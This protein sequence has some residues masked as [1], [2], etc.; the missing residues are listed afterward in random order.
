MKE[1][2]RKWLKGRRK[3]SEEQTRTTKTVNVEEQGGTKMEKKANKN[4]NVE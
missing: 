4:N 3:Y 2:K 1:K